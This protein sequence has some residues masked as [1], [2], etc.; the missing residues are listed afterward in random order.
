MPDRP[1]RNAVR[2]AAEQLAAYYES[3]LIEHEIAMG[4]GG[5]V[6]L[7]GDYPIEVPLDHLRVLWE[8]YKDQSNVIKAMRNEYEREFS[9]KTL[10]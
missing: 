2:A 8:Y 7:G 6:P 5:Y 9:G 4:V 3:H 1:D 10:E